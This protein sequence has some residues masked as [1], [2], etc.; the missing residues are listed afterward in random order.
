MTGRDRPRLDPAT[1]A[2][3]PPDAGWGPLLL[4]VAVGATV[5]LTSPFVADVRDALRQSAGAHYSLVLNLIVAGTVGVA[6][7]AALARIRGHRVR[8]GTALLAAVVL[9]ALYVW[10]NALPGVERF[11]FLEYGLITV[12][13]YRVVLARSPGRSADLSL[14]VVPAISA[15]I[16]ATADEWVQWFVPR[17]YGEI[18]DIFLNAAAIGCGLLFS[19]GA[20]PPAGLRLRPAPRS[21]SL[22]TKLAAMAVIA[23]AAFL[24]SVHLGY[25]LDDPEIGRFRSRHTAAELAAA[26]ADRGLRW[27]GG[28]PPEPGK[29]AREDQYLTE[30]LWHVQARN[31][32]WARQAIEVS[33][34]ENLILEKYFAPVLRAGHAWSPAQRADAAARRGPDAG[35]SF[36]SG[37]ARYPILTWDRRLVAIAAVSAAGLLLAISFTSARAAP[38]RRREGGR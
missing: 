25:L 20:E 33:W 3:A 11:H 19:L 12:L 1:S 13:F 32:A 17:R 38:K 16:V 28:P 5:V 14:I 30:G 24:W 18:R 2:A 4:A 9:G 23:L 31:E 26:S 6:G 15:V 29:V 36:A 34:R 8:R 22:M 37:A 10:I 21:L 35:R 27:R 7:L